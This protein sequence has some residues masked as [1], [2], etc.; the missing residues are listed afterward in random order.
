MKE[1]VLQHWELIGGLF[2]TIFAFFSGK[3]LKVAE[4]TK[5]AS[6]ALTS[7]QS[8]Y[9]TWVKDFKDRYDELKDEIKIYR[10]E[11]LST[12]NEIVEIRKENIELRKELKIWE[13]KYNKL[14]KEF[15]Q[16]KNKKNEN[17]N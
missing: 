4:E 14:K 16:L 12:R 6:D 8:T 9:D 10:D 7:M 11:Q 2:T 3:K 17:S 5:S 13:E 15:D 1:F